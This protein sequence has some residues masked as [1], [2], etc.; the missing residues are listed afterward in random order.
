M[1]R[2][3]TPLRDRILDGVTIDPVSGCWYPNLSTSRDGYAQIHVRI[4]GRWSKRN[5]HR[6]LYEDLH[7]P[8]P[9]QVIDHRCH[10]DDA[11]CPGGPTCLHRRCVN[12]AHLEPVTNGENLRRGRGVAGVNSAKTEC[13]NGHP[14]DEAN[15]YVRPA[16]GHRQCRACMADLMRRK[17]AA[18]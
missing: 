6:A 14:F 2:R 5:A 1:P 17:R 10:T 3:P 8:A 15:T 12:P 9:G 13:V 7:G 18:T 16:S 4:D 11:T